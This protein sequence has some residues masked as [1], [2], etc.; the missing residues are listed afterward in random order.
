MFKKIILVTAALF[1]SLGILTTSVYRTA[2]VDNPQSPSLKFDVTEESEEA[3]LE[4]KE[5]VDYD[6]T[7]PGLLPDHFLYPL[8]MVRDRIWLWLTTDPLK[9]AELLLRLADKRIWSA[10][11]LMDKENVELAVSTVTKAEKYLEQ[12]V[13]QEEVAREKKKDTKAFLEKL[14]QAGLKHE[15]VLLG[16]RQKVSEEANPVIN[17]CLDYARRAYQQSRER[18]GE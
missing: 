14:A 8:K 4:V 11:M 10:Q 2:A 5:L 18:L 9:K 13:D 12:A 6:L 16:I 7:Y 15:E 17:S 3:T 1:F